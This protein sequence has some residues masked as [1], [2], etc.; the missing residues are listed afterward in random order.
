MSKETA[1]AVL[2]IFPIVYWLA[3][4]E[5][6]TEPQGTRRILSAVRIGALYASSAAIYLLVRSFILRGTG[7]EEGKHSFAEVVFSSPQILS[8][9]VEKLFWPSGLAGF[10][11]NQLVSFPTA[12]MYL[13]TGVLLLGTGLFVWLA[14]RFSGV[15]AFAGV[16]ILLPLLPALAGIRVYD[17]GNMT[18]D[19]YL[20]L[21][22]VGL[23]LLLSLAVGSVWRDM[24]ARPVVLLICVPI[25]AFLCYLTVRQQRFY[26]DDEAFYERAIAVDSRNALVMGYLGDAYLEKNENELAMEWFERGLRTAPNDPN[27]KFYLARGLMK[28]QQYSAAEPYLKDLAYGSQ[29][30]AP[31]RKSA[32]LLSLAN[33]EMQLNE[34]DMAER[35]LKDLAEFDFRFPGLHRTLGIVFQRTG[36]IEDAQKEYALEFQ[37]SSDR[38]SG[39]QAIALARLLR[40]FQ[41]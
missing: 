11:V 19:R 34:P 27:A 7:I 10:Y 31:K 1:I 15:F 20:Y 37:I 28:T 29:P 26:H 3:P 16:L 32:L 36:K 38:E 14:C 25:F 39:R 8:F 2:P 23:C 33:A 17:Q 40:E 21:P 24:R 30:I 5:K 9:Y 35:T 12:R 22:S 41:H 18:H 6:H 13:A 4:T